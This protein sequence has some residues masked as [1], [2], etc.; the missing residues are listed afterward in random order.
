MVWEEEQLLNNLTMF[1]NSQLKEY[2]KI[3]FN[4]HIK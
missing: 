2:I 4:N 3:E 1:M